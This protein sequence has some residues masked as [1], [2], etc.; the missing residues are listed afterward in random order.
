MSG[1]DLRN[2]AILGNA[3]QVRRLI[4]SGANPC[5]RDQDGMTALHYAAWNGNCDC[6]DFLAINC[7]GSFEF[8]K[9]GRK[10]LNLRTKCGYTPLHL[11]IQSGINVQRCCESLLACGCDPSV[12]D[13]FGRRSIDLASK[14]ANNDQLVALLERGPEVQKKLSVLFECLKTRHQLRFTKNYE[15]RKFDDRLQEDEILCC[16]QKAFTSKELVS[17]VLKISQKAIDDAVWHQE[18]RRKIFLS[19][20]AS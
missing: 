20:K 1:D 15:A 2:Q 9:K 4:E 17:T 10:S 7:L 11:S 8:L 13:D 5:S 16:S 6:V 12:K 18:R 3:K 14:I 19:R